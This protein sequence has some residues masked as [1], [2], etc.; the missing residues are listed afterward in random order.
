M[1]RLFQWMQGGEEPALPPESQPTLQYFHCQLCI[2]HGVR[3]VYFSLLTSCL[4]SFRFNFYAFSQL[5]PQFSS[6]WLLL[7]YLDGCHPMLAL[8]QI[9]WL[10]RKMRGSLC[11]FSLLQNLLREW[12]VAVLVDYCSD[13]CRPEN[14][15]LGDLN[16]LRTFYTHYYSNSLQKILS[17]LFS[18]CM[19]Y[20]CFQMM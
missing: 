6:F 7:L 13:R 18:I 5:F 14:A 16:L 8:S 2:S 12:L 4:L 10:W 11:Y 17:C 9:F 20:R 15:F 1:Q 3:G 19:I